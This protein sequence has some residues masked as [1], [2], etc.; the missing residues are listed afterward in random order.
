MLL[1][2]VF[3]YVLGKKTIEE[4]S[5]S[6]H[7]HH[8]GSAI[9]ALANDTATFV[10]GSSLHQIGW[11]ISILILEVIIADTTSLRSRLL[12]SYVPIAPSLCNIWISGEVLMQMLKIKSWRFGFWVWCI[13]CPITAL[14][15][16][17][18]LL[19][20]QRKAKKAGTL[21]NYKTPVQAHGAWEVTKAL[22]WQLDLIGMILAICVFGFILVPLTMNN[23]FYPNWNEAKIIAPL[24]IGVL[25]IPLWIKWEGIAPH[26]MV[27]FYVSRMLQF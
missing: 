1:T 24:V 25:C 23:S 27:P 18:S 13:I 2:A 19:W 14:P 4:A 26:P 3:F 9:E 15:L 21:E 17:L 8:P 7:L 16:V 12:F 22:F 10:V 20:V 11:V 5:C 6:L